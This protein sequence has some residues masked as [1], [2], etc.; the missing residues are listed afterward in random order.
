M[1]QIE[2]LLERLGGRYSSSLGIDLSGN[3]EKE[4]FKWF[5]AAKLYAARIGENIA[6]RTY[7]EF[8]KENLLTPN[9]ISD[10]G[11]DKLVAVLDRGGYA[12][13]DF[14]TAT[15]LLAITKDLIEKYQGRLSKLERVSKDNEDLAKR[16]KGLGKGI[17]DVT[18]NIFL[19]ELRDKWEK[20]N[21]E[22]SDFVVLGA[23]KLGIVTGR[24]SKK[25]VLET[26]KDYWQRHKVKSFDFCDFEAA[27]LKLGKNY[28]RKKKD[29]FWLTKG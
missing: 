3:K 21:P 16:L 22:V 4:I 20:A 27:L 10:A 9:A 2:I 11:W 24:R 18:V 5:L 28:I 29:T 14:S 8:A 17:G 23:R 1:E 19:R 12:R 25:K 7:Q 15:K 6:S 26:L 13:Y